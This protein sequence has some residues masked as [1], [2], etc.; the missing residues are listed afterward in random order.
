VNNKIY[1]MGGEQPIALSV[2]EEYDPATDKWTKKANMPETRAELS[3][4][5]V[6]GIIYA[7]GG[8]LRCAVGVYNPVTDTWT[9]KSTV[10]S[11]L[12][13]HSC[14]VVNGIIYVISGCPVGS[15]TGIPLVQAYDPLT[16]TWTK[17]AD[18][19]TP[20]VQFPSCVLGGKIYVIGGNKNWV[21]FAGVDGGF[22]S[23][24]EI[25][26][27]G[28]I[29]EENTTSISPEAKIVE[30]WGYMKTFNP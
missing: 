10:P 15:W 3:A 1:V 25:Y 27:T 8:S 29:P 22:L 19:P 7:I 28:F 17:K 30:T 5:V 6:N 21:S 26:D 2:M 13:G 18:I 12:W 9:Q 23:S 14:N 16:D 11:C 24:V 4:G 20:R